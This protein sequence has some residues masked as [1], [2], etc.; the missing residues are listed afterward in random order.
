VER[1]TSLEGSVFQALAFLLA[2][3]QWKTGQNQVTRKEGRGR[4]KESGQIVR[5]QDPPRPIR[6]VLPECFK[7]DSRERNRGTPAIRNME[8]LLEDCKFISEARWVS[9]GLR[10]EE[11]GQ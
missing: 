9:G 5:P 3:P 4:E 6:Q 8:G 11:A 10:V 2:A 7:C 1:G